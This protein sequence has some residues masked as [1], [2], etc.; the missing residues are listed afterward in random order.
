MTSKFPAMQ[1]NLTPSQMADHF[2]EQKHV[3][4]IS[5]RSIFVLLSSDEVKVPYH[6]PVHRSRHLNVFEPVEKQT[7]A[8]SSARA[9][10]TCQ[11][12][13]HVIMKRSELHAQT[14]IIAEN[15]MTRE[16]GALPSYQNSP[17]STHRWQKFKSIKAR[18]TNVFRKNLSKASF[19][20]LLCRHTMS[21]KD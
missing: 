6:R 9:I 7:F 13:A 1:R 18:R 14:E 10:N 19:F 15:F 8:L 21:Q 16:E 5:P 20:C 11:N 2:T 4:N 17:R 3:N 12:P